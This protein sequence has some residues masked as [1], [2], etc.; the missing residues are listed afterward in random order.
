MLKEL[1]SN[2][3]LT[4][5]Q[6]ENKLAGLDSYQVS[7][8]QILQTSNGQQF[9]GDGQ[10]EA[11]ISD[12]IGPGFITD[13]SSSDA[14]QMAQAHQDS[15]FF[16]LPGNKDYEFQLVRMAPSLDGQRQLKIDTWFKEG[17]HVLKATAEN[18]AWTNFHE[19][20]HLD[21]A[22]QQQLESSAR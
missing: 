4:P 11:Y 1:D 9:Q 7:Q 13:M 2:P 14:Q 8:G 3:K 16:G 17:H 10:L 20:L 5:F 19:E 21:K 6:L 12:Q 15:T 22:R 18:G